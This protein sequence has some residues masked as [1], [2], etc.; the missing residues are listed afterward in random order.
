MRKPTVNCCSDY[1]GGIGYY[2]YSFPT[3]KKG[4]R[5]CLFH[6]YPRDVRNSVSEFCRMLLNGVLHMLNVWTS[7][8]RSASYS[9]CALIAPGTVITPGTRELTPN[10]YRFPEVSSSASISV[11]EYTGTPS[12]GCIS[13]AFFHS[14]MLDTAA[15]SPTASE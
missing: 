5:D 3:L 8:P 7:A 2:L 11:E 1:Y 9:E 10:T 12:V 4:M 15:L 13:I 14:P 6:I